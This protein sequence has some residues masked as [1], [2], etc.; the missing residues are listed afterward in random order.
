MKLKVITVST[1]ANS[2]GLR[3]MILLADNGQGYQALT[4][5]LNLRPAGTVMEINPAHTT[6]ELAIKSHLIR[7]GYE[8]I[9]RLPDANQGVVNLTF[10]E[11]PPLPPK[12]TSRKRLATTL[13]IRRRR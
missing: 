5:D 4:N 8:C 11:F 3:S 9:Q 1:N 7:C 10:Q 6:E 12:G 2:F 13:K